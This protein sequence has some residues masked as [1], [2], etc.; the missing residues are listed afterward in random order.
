MKK[1]ATKLISRKVWI[2]KVG[3]KRYKHIETLLEILPVKKK[4]ETV[5]IDLTKEENESPQCY[6]PEFCPNTPGYCPSPRFIP[7]PEPL[8]PEEAAVCP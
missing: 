1:G 4:A 2:L 7:S 6:S 5:V 3:N 8:F